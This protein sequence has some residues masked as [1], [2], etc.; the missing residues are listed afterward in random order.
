MTAIPLTT[1]NPVTRTILCLYR[2][3][4]SALEHRGPSPEAAT[5]NER[6]S[7]FR[8]L[9]KEFHLPPL[10]LPPTKHVSYPFPKIKQKSTPVI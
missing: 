6:R 4:D 7:L 5:L 10:P 8:Q 1:H 9:V 3:G 2:A